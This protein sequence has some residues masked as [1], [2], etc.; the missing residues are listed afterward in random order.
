MRAI[1]R[2][3]S[4][5]LRHPKEVTI[6]VEEADVVLRRRDQPDLRLS[7]A[8]RETDRATAYAALGRTLRNLAVHNPKAL[9]EALGEAF[10][11][12]E[13]LPRADR[14]VFVDEFSRVAAATAELDSYGP[15]SQLVREWRATAEVHAEPT[16]AQRLRRPTEAAGGRIQ[17]PT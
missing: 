13:F 14:R 9:E 2:P 10:P 4:D 11:W 16:L 15:M 7:R 12:L 8:D 3:F 1:E 6:E 5:L 17:P